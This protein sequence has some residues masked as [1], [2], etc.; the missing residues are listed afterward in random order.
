MRWGF[1]VIIEMVKG[2]FYNLIC[3]HIIKKKKGC[4]YMCCTRQCKSNLR[5]FQVKHTRWFGDQKPPFIATFELSRHPY[6]AEVACVA[7]NHLI[8]RWQTF[9]SSLLINFRPFPFKISKQL[10]NWNNLFGM[11]WS[12]FF[13]SNCFIWNNL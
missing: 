9:F 12:L 2:Q 1:F 11:I 4:W 6:R 5:A 13:I 3:I 7:Y 8:W 10:F